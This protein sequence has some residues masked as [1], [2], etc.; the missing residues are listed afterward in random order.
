LAPAPTVRARPQSPF[1]RALR[2]ALLEDFE[3]ELLLACRVAELAAVG[4]D[5]SEILR[6]L[7][8]TQGQYMAADVRLRRVAHG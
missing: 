2:A 4:Y 6:T 8:V 7:D 1:L 5:R 3:P